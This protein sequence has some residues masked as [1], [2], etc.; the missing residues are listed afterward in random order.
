[1]RGKSVNRSC[2]ANISGGRNSH[3]HTTR[4][5]NNNSS[6]YNNQ[7]PHIQIILKRMRDRSDGDSFKLLKD[8]H[9]SQ[10]KAQ[11]FL[12][13]QGVSQNAHTISKYKPMPTPINKKYVKFPVITKEVSKYINSIHPINPLPIFNSYPFAH[14]EEKEGGNYKFVSLSIGGDGQ[15]PINKERVRMGG[16]STSKASLHTNWSVG[17]VKHFPHPGTGPPTLEPTTTVP[18]YLA[19]NK[20]YTNSKT[21]SHH[22]YTKS[23]IDNANSRLPMDTPNIN[24]K[25]S[26]GP[27]DQ[28]NILIP[29]KKED[30]DREKEE[31]A[32]PKPSS[33][34]LVR[35]RMDSE[36]F[37]AQGGDPMEYESGG[38]GESDS[39][40]APKF[41]SVSVD[42]APL[43]CLL[44][45][46]QGTP[47]Y[48]SN[49]YYAPNGKIK[50]GVVLNRDKIPLDIYSPGNSPPFM[51]EDAPIDPTHHSVANLLVKTKDKDGRIVERSIPVP[52][53]R[54]SQNISMRSEVSPVGKLVPLPRE[55]REQWEEPQIREPQ[56]RVKKTGGHL[57]AHSNMGQGAKNPYKY[58]YSAIEYWTNKNY[59]RS[60]LFGEVRK[61]G[62]VEGMKNIYNKKKE[63]LGVIPSER[64]SGAHTHSHHSETCRSEEGGE[65]EEGKKSPEIEN[66]EVREGH[67]HLGDRGEEH[68]YGHGHGHGYGHELLP[69]I[70]GTGSYQRRSQEKHIFREMM[71]ISPY[72]CQQFRHG[73][74]MG[75]NNVVTKSPGLGAISLRG[76]SF[77]IMGPP[78]FPMGV[79]HPPMGV[80]HPP[81]GVHHPPQLSSK[82]SHAVSMD[83]I[84]PNIDRDIEKKYR[85]S[86]MQSLDIHSICEE[87]AVAVAP[88]HH[89]FTPTHGG[90]Q[91][92]GV[93]GV[94]ITR[95]SPCPS[96]PKKEGE[97][98]ARSLGKRRSI[99]IGEEVK[100][101][102][103]EGIET[104]LYMQHSTDS[105]PSQHEGSYQN[106]C[107]LRPSERLDQLDELEGNSQ[108]MHHA[109]AH[110]HA[111]AHAH[112]H[113]ICPSSWEKESEDYMSEF[114]NESENVSGE[115]SNQ[116][117]PIFRGRGSGN[118][119][120]VREEESIPI[121]IQADL[122]SYHYPPH[123]Q[124]VDRTPKYIHSHSHS[125]THTHTTHTHSI[126]L[127][128]PLDPS[129]PM[130]S[131]LITHRLKDKGSLHAQGG[132]P[133]IHPRYKNI[134]LTLLHGVQ[135]EAFLTPGLLRRGDNDDPR[136]HN[137]SF[138]VVRG[139]KQ[140]G[141]A[142]R[143]AI[144]S[145]VVR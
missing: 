74:G 84:E 133:H 40:L 103:N 141:T 111:H 101:P 114:E 38:Y 73:K 125:H 112:G 109:H 45:G 13:N 92:L 31:S 124:S 142:K 79:H 81:M 36:E 97:E 1:M 67:P 20:S 104:P 4:S 99:H 91:S 3:K 2:H 139:N 44:D 119:G 5:T 71:S 61:K 138:P 69:Q 10:S 144:F 39:E 93:G 41:M 43:K 90:S 116:L 130:H 76:V 140:K 27:N 42:Q 29:K 85:S 129:P 117:G 108:S 58:L 17:R 68:G 62:E 77:K 33:P 23:L 11:L 32:P 70:G 16:A 30:R 55:Y 75:A 47:T 143:R 137:H 110:D 51:G 78:G 122:N 21:K 24:T 49:S 6:N 50:R 96:P 12:Q 64:V 128:A 136:S 80:H 107:V 120:V 88:K 106:I 100:S 8:I 9:T 57:R 134:P 135:G 48:Q 126:P 54:Y 83:G 94:K 65:W 121:G 95:R 52:R 37:G 72:K 132:A 145:S 105:T 98:R 131:T 15:L 7:E 59:R 46:A 53:Q 82:E 127:A 87:V 14:Q 35:D 89:S 28:D 123:S 66:S 34:I 113:R 63:V 60:N 19:L 115:E 22:S 56:T 102:K 25:T 86:Q 26:E 118:K 18:K